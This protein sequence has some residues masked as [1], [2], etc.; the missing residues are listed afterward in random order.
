MYNL[1]TACNLG[2]TITLLLSMIGKCGQVREK[3]TFSGK[4]MIILFHTHHWCFF[5]F[6]EVRELLL[7]FITFSCL[8]IGHMT[9]CLLS[10]SSPW[11]SGWLAAYSAPSPEPEG[12]AAVVGALPS[13]NH[14][15]NTLR[16][17][18]TISSTYL[19]SSSFRFFFLKLFNYLFIF[20]HARSSLL[21]LDFLS[22]RWVGVTL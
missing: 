22:L 16:L 12:G 17:F 1:N 20:G 11:T 9:L 5:L 19:P 4:R 2:I 6:S 3:E 21:C 7:W 8:D 14:G 13:A 10:C 15:W 18:S